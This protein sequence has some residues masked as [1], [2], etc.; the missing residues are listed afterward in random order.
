MPGFALGSLLTTPVLLAV[1][2]GGTPLLALPALAMAVVL[3]ARLQ[4]VLHGPGGSARRLTAPTGV[5]DWPGFL[6]LTAVV[7]VRSVLF[8][9]LTSF[10]A[11]YFIDELGASARLGG[12]ALTVFLATGAVGTLLGGVIADRYSPVTAIQTGFALAV[13][14]LL[15]LV[16]SPG[17]VVALVFVTVTGLSVF[18]PFSV[19]VVLGQDYLPH[20]IGTASGVTVGLAVSVGGL[21]G[22]LLGALA[23][24]TS[25]RLTL[26][27]LLALP[28]LALLLAALLHDPGSRSRLPA[29]RGAD[30]ASVGD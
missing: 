6:R 26:A 23:D 29:R 13:P 16:L 30:P 1:G 19:F 28:V 15:G 7:T 5:D 27:A 9:G 20:R 4:R 24:A 22:P 8:F 21:C 17:P 11:L 10:L 25:L 14:G 3:A 12:A 18:M 2:L